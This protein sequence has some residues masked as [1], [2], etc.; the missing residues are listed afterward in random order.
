MSHDAASV[1][2]LRLFGPSSHV[3]TFGH[4]QPDMMLDQPLTNQATLYFE[5]RSGCCGPSYLAE[6]VS[7]A[8]DALS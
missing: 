3:S 6:D 1:R 7:T 8:R 5:A 4:G 2:Q